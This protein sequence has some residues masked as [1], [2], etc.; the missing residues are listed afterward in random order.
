[1]VSGWAQKNKRDSAPKRA[2]K[3]TEQ[4]DSGSD[5]SSE[6]KFHSH[7]FKS[8]AS[9]NPGDNFASYNIIAEIGKGSY[10]KV[11][12]V[13]S[14][15]D[16]EKYVLKKINIKH[17][18]SNKVLD[19]MKEVEILQRVSHPHIIQYYTS[20]VE[21]QYLSIVME[22]AE[23][24]DLHSRIKRHKDKRNM[25]NEKEIWQIAHEICLGIYYLHSNNILHRDIKP[26]NILL[27]ADYHVKI[28][29]LGVS[30]IVSDS[31]AMLGTR[32][33]TPLYLAPELV[34]QQK[35]DMKVLH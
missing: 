24:G 33:G 25:F 1:M 15:L 35:Y 22:Y 9:R 30:K 12:L 6:N 34:R 3:Q 18:K 17:L 2:E 23:G 10:G 7:D 28:G 14:L 26:L 32:V 29:D 4:K 13:E 5:H 16:F 31:A 20:F 21:D 19:A 11:Y 27:T 8:T